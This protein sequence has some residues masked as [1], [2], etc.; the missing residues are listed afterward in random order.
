MNSPNTGK[1]MEL[2]REKKVLEFRKESF[3]VMY[4][5][6]RCTDTGEE[7]EDE[8]LSDL[9]L[10]QVY[11]A[12]RVRHK[13]PFPEEI[14]EIRSRYD[15]PATTMS[16]ILGF[17]INQYRLYE[18]GEVPSETN[19]RLIQMAGNPEEFLRLVELSDISEGRQKEKLLKRGEE[20]RMKRDGWQVLVEKTLGVSQPSE[21]NG[22]RKTGPE[23]AYQMV[24]FFAE[25]LKPLKTALNKLLFYADFYHYKRFGMGISGL[26]YRAIQWGPVPSQ[27]EYLFKMAEE[28]GVIDL[29]Y[30]LW[31][32]EKEIVIVDPSEESGFHPEFFTEAEL[33]SLRTVLEKF[34]KARTSQLVDVSH[35]EPAWKANI[36]QKKLISYNYAFDLQAL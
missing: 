30:E 15:L 20:L 4:H 25:E 22:Y 1:P 34:R 36:D 17:G 5:V 14:R 13:L 6:Y 28:N 21:F 8:Q 12:Y 7:F 26:Q 24:R 19:A 35:N 33:V 10:D 9:N 29:R 11:N 27:F 23:K 18:T 32:N 16:Q 2:Q 3:E 31:E